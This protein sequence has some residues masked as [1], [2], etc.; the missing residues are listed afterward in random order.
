MKPSQ[1]AIA[2]HLVIEE[3]ELR[4]LMAADVFGFV[5]VPPIAMS[6]TGLSTNSVEDFYRSVVGTEGGGAAGTGM[7]DDGAFNTAVFGGQFA[8][9]GPNLSGT[10]DPFSPYATT[11]LGQITITTG[12]NTLGIGS[13]ATPTAGPSRA[14]GTG[15]PDLVP[16]E[17]PTSQ[18]SSSLDQLPSEI[19]LSRPEKANQTKGNLAGRATKPAPVELQRAT[20]AALARGMV[21]ANGTGLEAAAASAL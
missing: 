15:N 17:E 16:I 18:E 5:S 4:N 21:F 6:A 19:V 14:G 20:D 9:T 3:L 11:G 2:K 1:H 8:A 13:F 10:S 7:F 12:A